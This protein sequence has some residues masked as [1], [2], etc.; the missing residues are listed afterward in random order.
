L[1]QFLHL[2]GRTRQQDALTR[3]RTLFHKPIMQ[4]VEVEFYETLAPQ[5]YS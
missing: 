3:Q 1:R 2:C 4:Q 5:A